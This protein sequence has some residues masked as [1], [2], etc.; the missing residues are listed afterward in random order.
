M[1][2]HPADD[3]DQAIAGQAWQET[4]DENALTTHEREDN[5]QEARGDHRRDEE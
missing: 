2:N 5:R 4:D 3:Y 1:S